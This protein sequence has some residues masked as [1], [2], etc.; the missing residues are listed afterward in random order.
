MQRRGLTRY[1]DVYLVFGAGL[2]TCGVGDAAAAVTTGDG[3][4]LA[5]AAVLPTPERP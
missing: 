4:W 2:L 5:V 3:P 1:A